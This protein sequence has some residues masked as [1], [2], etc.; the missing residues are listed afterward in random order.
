MAS[1][2]KQ[3]KEYSILYNR[4]VFE[5]LFWGHLVIWIPFLIMPL[6]L[7]LEAM[8]IL[9]I[10]YESQL[11]I[12]KGCSLTRLQQKLGV[13]PPGSEYYAILYGRVFHRH[14]SEHQ[15]YMIT[16]FTELYALSAPMIRSLFN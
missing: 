9:V 15:S 1:R 8:V 16:K 12:F 14:L 7:P 11:I 4:F 5:L 2:N 10:I 3:T 6:F 13:L